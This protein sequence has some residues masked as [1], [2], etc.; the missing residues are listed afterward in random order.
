MVIPRHPCTLL[1]LFG[2]LYLYADGIYLWDDNGDKLQRTIRYLDHG[3][4]WDMAEAM[5]TSSC[6]TLRSKH[7]ESCWRWHRLSMP[8]P[9]TWCLGDEIFGD[10]TIYDNCIVLKYIEHPNFE[11]TVD[12][13]GW[14]FKPVVVL[15]DHPLFEVRGELVAGDKSGQLCSWL[16]GMM[17]YHTRRSQ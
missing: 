12:F 5:A 1:W 14:R 8:W 13:N 4:A 3:W 7:V 9:W 16:L 2:G 15:L 11:E 6:G 10:R 17:G